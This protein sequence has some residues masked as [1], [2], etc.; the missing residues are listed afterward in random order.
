MGLTEL[1][2]DRRGWND[3]MIININDRTTSLPSKME[4]LPDRKKIISDLKSFHS[5]L[6]PSSSPSPL[7]TANNIFSTSLFNLNNNI[8][9]NNISNNSSNNNSNNSINSNSNPNLPNNNHN[10]G[11]I[12][13]SVHALKK[14]SNIESGAITNSI[15][16]IRKYSSTLL[17]NYVNREMLFKMA[18]EL[19]HQH[20]IEIITKAS[21]RAHQP[22][23]R[24]LIAT[25]QFHVHVGRIHSVDLIANMGTDL[26]ATYHKIERLLEE[27]ELERD[28]VMRIIKEH[29]EKLSFLEERVKSLNFHKDQIQTTLRE[30]SSK[31]QI[32]TTLQP[33][34]SSHSA[35][36][37]NLAPKRAT[38][39]RNKSW[40]H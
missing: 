20:V 4:P 2:E 11:K 14:A 31:V 5:I 15:I 34:N 33:S 35:N 3:P 29:Q 26:N 32:T 30:N 13:N 27:T 9:N 22:F 17:D 18:A 7:N 38:H 25:Q 37:L 10:A 1:P 16:L 12:L 36:S 24:Q 40:F 6:N 19:H 21:N 28:L 39:K 8:N 23:V